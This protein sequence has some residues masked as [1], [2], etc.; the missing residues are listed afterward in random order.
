MGLELVNIVGQTVPN[1]INRLKTEA[2]LIGLYQCYL[3]QI[4][5]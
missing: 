3:K 5:R 2:F 4:V 1:L